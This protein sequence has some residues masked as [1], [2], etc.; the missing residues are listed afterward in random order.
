[1]TNW[2]GVVAGGCVSDPISGDWSNPQVV[3][4][5]DIGAGNSGTDIA[6]RLPY[7]FMS[8]TAQSSSKPDLFVFDVSNPAIPNLVNSIDI[9]SS[10]INSIFIKGNYLYAASSNNNKEL[11]IFNIADPPNASEIASL[12]LSGYANALGVTTFA[13]TTAIG[14][15][16]SA[17]YELAFI[18]VTNP[19]S[20]QLMSQIATGGNVYDFYSTNKRLYFVSQESDEDIW[21]YNIEDPADPVFIASYDIPGTTEDIS[22]YAQDKEGNNLLVG[23]IE[24]EMTVI[25]ATNTAQMYLRDRINV[26]GDVNDITCVAGNLL[27]LATSNSGKEF[28][29]VDGSDPDNLVEYASLNFPQIGTGIEYVQNTVYMSVRS[30]DSLRIIGPGP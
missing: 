8:G 29:I 18:D 16:G 3:G 5:A 20:P 21:I 12:N 4:T 23:N 25:G 24:N 10:G 9:G 13:S 6:V 11:I 2:E 30:N 1:L 15:S 22:I 7:V 26:G 19:A 27:F 17:T 28:I 14:R